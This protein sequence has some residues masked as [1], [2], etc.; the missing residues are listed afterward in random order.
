[1]YNTNQIQCQNMRFILEESIE[2]DR[3]IG[4]GRSFQSMGPA[5]MK[6]KTLN[7]KDHNQVFWARE[8][9]TPSKPLF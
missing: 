9:E 1:M 5:F 4:T 7:N 3:W 2:G 8:T 6:G